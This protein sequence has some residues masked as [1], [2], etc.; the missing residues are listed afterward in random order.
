MRGNLLTNLD[1]LER[2]EKS[3]ALDLDLSFNNLSSSGLS[4]DFELEPFREFSN[5]RSLNVGNSFRGKISNR[6]NRFS[7]SLMYLEG[8]NNLRDLDISNTD[9]NRGLECLPDTLQEI[10]CSNDFLVNWT[11]GNGCSHIVQRL[12]SH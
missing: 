6:Y 8:K 12:R 11:V 4:P 9:I 1:F 10:R 3:R 5:L 2:L 7:G